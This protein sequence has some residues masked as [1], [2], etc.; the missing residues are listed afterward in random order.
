VPSLVLDGNTLQLVSISVDGQP[1]P[2]RR[3]LPALLWYWHA[4]SHR[5][6]L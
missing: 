2:V 6:I 5:F 1:V 3:C 4:K